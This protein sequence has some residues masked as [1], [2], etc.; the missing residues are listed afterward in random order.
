MTTAEAVQR[1]ADVD[2]EKPG[3]GLAQLLANLWRH[4]RPYRTQLWVL[5][6]LLLIDAG[7]SAALPLG[8]KFLVDEAIGPQNRTLLFWVLSAL[9]AAQL[10]VSAAA[11]GRDWFY[12][13]VGAGVMND[14]RLAMFEQLQSLSASF[15]GLNQAG[16]VLARF[17]TDLA[18]VESTVSI[19]LPWGMMATLTIVWSLAVLFVLQWQ[20]ALLTLVAVPLSLLGPRLLGPRAA[21]AGY[22]LKQHEAMV[23]GSVQ[24]SLAGHYVVRA[25]GLQGRMRKAFLR[26]LRDLGGLSQRFN[27]LSGLVQRT[28]NLTVGLVHVLV[29]G[30][31]AFLT[32]RGTLSIG[33]LLSFDLVFLNFSGGVASLT[34]V[35]PSF[36]RASGGLARIEELLGEEPSVSDP[37]K[38][39]TLPR[40]A[41]A[42]TFRDVSFGYTSDQ[43]NLVGV[44]L[45]IPRGSHVAFVGRSG[46]GKS[47]LLSLLLR[48]HDPTSGS[49]LMDGVD[50]R[51]VKQSDVRRQMAIVSQESFLFDTSIR[52][53]LLAARPSAS[54]AEVEHAASL[55][56]ADAFINALPE[57]YDAVVGGRGERLSG[58]QR[59]RLAIA[60]ALLRDPAILLLDEATSALDAATENA[61]DRTLAKVGKGRT[62]IT[63]TH[64]LH[65]IVGAD[66]I[67]VL[68]DG[69]L[70][71]EGR[72]DDL[73]QRG[74]VYAEIWRR[75][76]G[77][78]IGVDGT[79]ASIMVERLRLAPLFRDLDPT[80]LEEVSHRFASE[81][82]PGD[83]VVLQE[84]DPGD[85][86]Y[87]IVRGRVAV[88]KVGA[89]NTERMVAVLETGDHFG[90]IALLRDVP[91]TATIRTLS[92]CMFLTLQRGH[93]V[94]LIKRVPDLLPALERIA[95]RR[96]AAEALELE[97][98]HPKSRGPLSLRR[99]FDAPTSSKGSPERQGVGAG[100]STS[101][102]GDDDQ[103]PTSRVRRPS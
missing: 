51:E 72:H 75:Q 97:H 8:I 59:Q 102:R 13:Y 71:E 2:D 48:F 55:A 15:H 96:A 10:V 35:A 44:S 65:S 87:I 94:E 91:S 28:P 47:T 33:A 78:Q 101:R 64:R 98:L 26:Q 88:S 84:G 11:I 27:F 32:F 76:N 93:F 62:V 3:L 17:T 50:L 36:L 42:I 38:P 58:G 53:N 20:L 39:T 68:D 43:L 66:R 70:V 49:V 86:F 61:L 95:Q 82:V 25:F 103:I 54:G 52:E 4:L 40:F 83:R 56:E 14:L 19:V 30:G 1:E 21:S 9:V 7:L 22:Q 45:E 23:T 29:L 6:L 24:E 74:G 100:P 92:A 31:A 60:R 41:R 12:A 18:A 77:L 63:V 5:L 80:V 46:S 89:G 16:D 99:A 79:I 69:R 34:E 85:R 37:E 81:Q 57:R 67:F 90:E 73:V